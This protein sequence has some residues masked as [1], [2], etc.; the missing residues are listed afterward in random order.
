MQCGGEFDDLVRTLLLVHALFQDLDSEVAKYLK[1]QGG[2]LVQGTNE[3]YM[4][5]ENSTL[6]AF[7]RA[8][9]ISG[10]KMVWNVH[11]HKMIGSLKQTP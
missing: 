6:K 2:Q 1:A 8:L 10:Q 11:A 3:I 9:P 5:M 7:R 4:S